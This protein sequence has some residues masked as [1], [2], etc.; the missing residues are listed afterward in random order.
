MRK[1]HEEL[2]AQVKA[3]MAELTGKEAALRQTRDKLQAIYDGMA[4]GFC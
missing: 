2:E 4:D 1:A 3:R